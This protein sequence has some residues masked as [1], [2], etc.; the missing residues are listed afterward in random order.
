VAVGAEAQGRSKS[1]PRPLEK[2]LIAALTTVLRHM[3]EQSDQRTNIWLRLL[4]NK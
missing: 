1:G 3:I 2:S 4:F